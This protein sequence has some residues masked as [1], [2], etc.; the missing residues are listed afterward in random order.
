MM[1]VNTI[2]PR[3]TRGWDE[4]AAWDEYAGRFSAK[5]EGAHVGLIRAASA[6]FSRQ[7]PRGFPESLNQLACSNMTVR[8]LAYRNARTPRPPTWVFVFLILP[9]DRAIE[10]IHTRLCG[11]HLERRRAR[12]LL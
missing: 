7:R 4:E 3:A 8:L 12:R 11:G 5:A 1:R 9:G 6:T 10:A 2:Q